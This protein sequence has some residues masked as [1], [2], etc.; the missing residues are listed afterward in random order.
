MSIAN[1]F[2]V[3]EEPARTVSLPDR[4]HELA[5]K[6]QTLFDELDAP[7]DHA[8]PVFDMST[9]GHS[10]KQIGDELTFIKEKMDDIIDQTAEKGKRDNHGNPF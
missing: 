6:L 4:L 3:K 10:L 8:N 2:I 9:L 5:N 7:E 1:V